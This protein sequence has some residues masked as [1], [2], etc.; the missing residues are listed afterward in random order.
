MGAVVGED[1]AAMDYEARLATL[2][3][4]GVGLWDVVAE[5][6]RKGSLDAAIQNVEESDLR[7]LVAALP[8]L[9]A[10][11]FNGGTSAKI[12]MKQLAGVK[13]LELVRLPSSSPAYA[14]RTELKMQAWSA[15]R[16]FLSA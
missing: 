14:G 4:H 3:R 16:R 15:L 13:G 1:L 2:L 6:E 7:T 9:R 12:G 10:V 5:A 11:A 8:G